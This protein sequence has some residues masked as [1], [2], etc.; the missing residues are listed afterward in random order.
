MT[1]WSS[2]CWEIPFVLEPCPATVKGRWDAVLS[3]RGCWSLSDVCRGSAKEQ[4]KDFFTEIILN[5]LLSL[6]QYNFV[7]C[8]CNI[9][10]E[11]S[12]TASQAPSVKPSCDAFSEVKIQIAS[13]GIFLQSVHARNIIWT[14]CSPVGIPLA[15]G[16]WN[17][18]TSPSVHVCWI[19]P[20]LLNSCRLWVGPSPISFTS[21]RWSSSLLITLTDGHSR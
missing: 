21:P 15:K 6:I 14:P 17:V 13:R 20:L 18:C 8:K 10:V 19:L 3:S 1:H 7:S 9:L 4:Q 5:I 11:A 16:V 12:V 2:G